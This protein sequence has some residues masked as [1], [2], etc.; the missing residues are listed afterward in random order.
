MLLGYT[1]FIAY[2]VNCR[3]KIVQTER[4]TPK[5]FESYAEVQPIFY[6]DSA[7]ERKALQNANSNRF[8]S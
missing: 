1:T 2:D 5:F 4:R 8:L 3:A 7:N 6:K